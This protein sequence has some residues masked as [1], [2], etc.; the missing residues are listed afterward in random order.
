MNTFFSLKKYNL[1]ENSVLNAAMEISRI[2]IYSVTT[3]AQK[4]DFDF[5]LSLCFFLSVP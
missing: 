1:S 5:Q 4:S 3:N 2:I